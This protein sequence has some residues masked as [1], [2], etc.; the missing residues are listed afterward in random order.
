MTKRKYGVTSLVVFIALIVGAYIVVAAPDGDP[1]ALP[2]QTIDTTTIRWAWN[3]TSTDEDGF[4]VRDT[5]D[6]PIASVGAD[7]TTYDESSFSENTQHARRVVAY[8]ESA[9]SDQDAVNY[10][11]SFTGPNSTYTMGFEFTVNSDITV[12]SVRTYTNGQK[13]TIWDMSRNVLATVDPAV[14]DA[15]WPSYSL[16]SPLNLTAGQTYMIAVR[17]T[18]YYYCNMPSSTSD[19]TIERSWYDTADDFPDTNSTTVTMY[20]VVNF[21]YHTKTIDPSNPT[22]D[23]SKYTAVHDPTLSDFTLSDQG[24]AQVLIDV[25][26]PPNGTAGETGVFVQRILEGENWATDAVDV[27]AVYTQVYGVTDTVPA[28]GTYLYRIRFQNGDFVETAWSSDKKITIISYPPDKPLNFSGTLISPTSIEWGWTDDSDDEEGFVIQDT[29]DV[30]YVWANAGATTALETGLSENTE[31]TR[32]CRSFI[33]P[34]NAE[35][36]ACTYDGAYSSGTATNYRGI[37]F[38]PQADIEITRLSRYAGSVV[39]LHSDTGT[40]LEQHTFST[41]PDAEWVEEDL[42]TPW[43]LSAGVRYRLSTYDGGSSYT[44]YSD[45]LAS[46]TEVPAIDITHG[47]YGTTYPS[48]TSSATVYGLVNFR[49]RLIS[50]YAAGY[51]GGYSTSSTTYSRGFRFTPSAD[52]WVTKISRRA[53][54]KV[55]IHDDSGTLLFEHDFTLPPTGSWV[56]ASLT[57]FLKL[58]AGQTY[59]ISTWDNGSSYTYYYDAL[60]SVSSDSNITIVGGCNGNSTSG[61]WPINADPSYVRGV[62]NFAFKT[63]PN[64]SAASDTDTLYTPVHEPLDTDMQLTDAGSAEVVITITKP[65]NHDVVSTG[66]YIER[67]DDEFDWTSPTELASGWD[68]GPDGDG[69][70]YTRIDTVPS[71]G[72]WWYRMKFRNQVG[73]ETGWYK[74]S[75]FILSY[76]PA[77]PTGFQANSATITT[78]S[79]TWEWTDVATDE[80]GYEIR[81]GS[82]TWIADTAEDSSSFTE[83]GLSE[84]TPYTRKCLAYNLLVTGP[85]AKDQYQETIYSTVYQMYADYRY[86][87]TFTPGVSGE[88]TKVEF[89]GYGYD[90]ATYDVVVEI[91]PTSGG[92]PD[93]SSA[94]LAEVAL[95]N[96][97]T[98]AKWHT[99]TFASPPMLAAG[100][101]YA[102]VFRSDGTS[103]LSTYRNYIYYE[104][105]DAYAGGQYYFYNSATSTW[106]P[107]ATYDFMFRTHMIPMNRN[108]S[109]AS[110]D[111]PVYTLVHGPVAADLSLTD[112]HSNG[113]VEVVVTPPPNPTAG[114]TAVYIERDTDPGFSSPVEIGGGWTTTYT[115]TDTVPSNDLYYYRITFRNGDGT[116]TNSYVDSIDVIG[117]PPNEPLA[118]YGDTITASSITWNWTDDSSDETGFEVQDDT[119]ALVADVGADTSSVVESSLSENTAYT[120]HCRSYV[121]AGGTGVFPDI[122]PSAATP[123]SNPDVTFH[124]NGES[125]SNMQVVDDSLYWSCDR[126]NFPANDPQEIWAEFEF[127]ISSTGLSGSE[128]DSMTFTSKVYFTG[129]SGPPPLNDPMEIPYI[130]QAKVQ[131]YNVTSTTWETMGTDFFSVFRPTVWDTSAEAAIWDQTTDVNPENPIIR[132]K[133]S[134]W[135]EDYVSAS[136]IKI[137][138]YIQGGFNS[139]ADEAVWIFDHVK[140]DLT[141]AYTKLYSGPT[142][143]DTQYTLVH[144]PVD[145]DL[146]LTDLGS[147]Q[148]QI[149]VTEPLNSTLPQTGVYIE[150]DLEGDWSG[151]DYAVIDGDWTQTYTQTDTVPTNG[152]WKY[153]IKFRNQAGTETGWYQDSINIIHYPPA[154]PEDFL[155]DS[156]SVTA[157]SITWEW[158]DK[159]TDEAGFEIR[160]GSGGWLADAGEDA[161]SYTETGLEENTAYT[162]KCVAYNIPGGGSSFPDIYPSAVAPGGNPSAYAL[163]SNGEAISN[164]Q[165]ESDSLYWSCDYQNF[166]AVDP[167]ELWA[168]FS[169]DISSTGLSGSDIGTLTFTS[170]VYFTGN[171]GTVPITDPMEIQYIDEAKVQIYNFTSTTWETVGSDFLNDLGRGAVWRDAAES[172]LWDFITDVN[173]DNPVVR[174]KDSGW[175]TDYVSANTIKVRVY[176][177]GAF[178]SGNWDATWVFDHVKI[179]I[180]AE[181]RNYSTETSTDTIYTAVHDPTDADFTVTPGLWGKA[182][183][184]VM[185]PKNSTL[186]QTAVRIRRSLN[187]DMSGAVI[188]KDFGIEGYSFEDDVPSGEPWYY[189]I[190]FRN[191]QGLVTVESNSV[192][193]DIADPLSVPGSFSGQGIAV[194]TIEWTW[195][196]VTDADAYLF[197]DESGKTLQVITAPDTSC[198]D[199]V[200]GENT[201]STRQ[202]RS[203]VFS[204][205]QS[206]FEDTSGL[207]QTAV[208]W[209]SS[210]A[211]AQFLYTPGELSDEGT[212]KKIYWQRTDAGASFTYANVTVRLGHTTLTSLGTSFALNYTELDATVVRDP[213]AYVVPVT[214][215]PNE[216]LE[217]P[218]D[219][220]FYYNGVHN[221]IVDI[222]VESGDGD[223]GWSEVPVTDTCAISGGPSD[224]SASVTYQKKFLIRFDMD[225]PEY[226]SQTAGPVMAYSLVHDATTGDFTLNWPGGL[227]VDIVVTEPPNGTSGLTGVKIERATDQ[228]FATDV[229]LVQDFAAN[230][231]LTDT[232]PAADIYWYRITYCN[233]DGDA[234]GT[235]GVEYVVATGA[236]VAPTAGFVGMPTLGAAPLTVDFVDGSTGDT[237]G[238]SWDFEN[239]GTPD[240]T[241]QNPTHIYASAGVYTVSLTVTGPAG[242]DTE[243]KTDY[244][245]V[246][247]PPVAAFSASP[248]SGVVALTVDFTDESTGSITS[249][250]WDFDNDGTPDSALQH[251]SY[252][253][254][255]AG[256]YTVSLTV[257]GPGGSTTE[258]KI[259]HI[260]VWE[261]PGAAFSGTPTTGGVGL[262]VSFTDE[263][264]GDITSWS[265]D[266]DND[267][268]PDSTEQHPSYT[269]GAA[270]TYTVSLTVT[271]PGG[272]DTETKT[273][274]ITVYDAPLAAFSANPTSGLVA[275]SVDFTDESTG[276]ITSWSWDFD[277]DGTPDSILQHPSHIYNTAGTYTVSLTVTGPGGSDTETR[278]DYISVWEPPAAEFS[279][280]P[281][282]G[283]APLTVDFL[284]ES[285]GDITSWSWDFDND[286]TPDSMEQHPS[287]IYTVVGTYTVSL[288]VSGPGGSSTETKVDYITVTGAPLAAFSAN[289]TSGLVALAVDFTD[290]STGSITSWSWDFDDDGTPDSIQQHPSYTYTM[291]GTYTVSLTV[292]G[293]GG[294][295]TETK[296]DYI[297]VW[298]P[299]VAEFSASPTSGTSPLVVDFTDEST[300]EVTSWEWDFENDGTP[301]STEQHPSHTYTMP[302]LYTVSLTVSGPG[303]SDTVTKIDYIEVTDPS[304][305]AADFSASP[306]SGPAPLAVAFT[307]LSTGTYTSVAWDFDGDGTID[308]TSANPTHTYNLVGTYTV[309]LTIDGPD[310]D[311]TET[312]VDYI[313]VTDPG[314]IS[315]E[316]TAAPTSGGPPL[317]VQFTDLSVGDIASWSWDFGNGG[318]SS[319]RSPSYQYTVAGV[320]TVTLTVTGPAGS[321]SEIKT[322]YITVGSAP[323]PPASDKKKGGCSCA[324]DD[325]PTPLDHLIGYFAPLF[326]IA[327]AWLAFRRRGARA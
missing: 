56:E 277:N 302:G 270:G 293:P 324:V 122:Y 216:W 215:S 211:R 110:T 189:A 176:M 198:Q 55:S 80:A 192:L 109:N 161:T 222:I 51:D 104:N 97:G 83:S 1:T 38:T 134:G 259:D 105:S 326:L 153:R 63:V 138:V 208:P 180:M 19:I 68:D 261:P 285:T 256:T 288:T 273:D 43:Q 327:C 86:A 34:Y 239:D 91:Y 121:T 244:I 195:D 258:T 186:L 126:Q 266:F 41:S 319:D 289:P 178:D 159:S 254:N 115:H 157:T 76:P 137:R 111:G 120:R 243:T 265:W 202:L 158:T 148:V 224:G 124:S 96:I 298:E 42:A 247:E 257:T 112:L 206:G 317:D 185:P 263:S 168:E 141:E 107:T 45:P 136:I 143:D 295:D 231:S 54:S 44:Y 155:A 264:T 35:A 20:G 269:Y 214:G 267:G 172:L 32:Q 287:Y 260:T 30:N 53:G 292:T 150:R 10:P 113:Q 103:S 26:A 200:S 276:A 278:I 191:A 274:Y 318:T 234:S 66:V 228:A 22:A 251:P 217:I 129:S 133:D 17:T 225:V 108:Y 72:T 240:S 296:T 64:Y 156:A 212:I 167:Q 179:D 221:L 201:P 294:S 242:S 140:I 135:S 299:P 190:T 307:D 37:R 25:T 162:R 320:Y 15:T 313:T 197:K 48:S 238:W 81:D 151:P 123:G 62:P 171:T 40:L 291:A 218:L 241:E 99:A 90:A 101:L 220:T 325:S 52:I 184:D 57:Q 213:A 73:V 248:T 117:Y 304:V 322:D 152:D 279:G 312:K 61:Q 187:S 132:T 60:G 130:D 210:G 305:P 249:W 166:P 75:I 230:Y 175:S 207:G 290:E 84:N 272:S 237:T 95:P 227:S 182:T 5:S 205:I 233:G 118:F 7:V 199:I 262:I 310:G 223:A 128:I 163:V 89:Y 314:S 188:V 85:E 23:M 14:G 102:M 144:E 226:Q 323:P 58:S 33:W 252:I 297:T 147:A 18:G 142:A 92:E 281:T 209:A 93:R 100:T 246:T 164:M 219:R 194:D 282:T 59:R 39:S 67:S 204:S 203:C 146:V 21:I 87:Q 309:T 275:L 139:T 165:A 232:I 268:T 77:D 71:N 286:G 79:I 8:T 169:F 27:T 177:N 255:T 193:A 78:T 183:I 69:D 181:N 311:D 245:T 280:D 235:S 11:G 173:P 36:D 300:G 170:K 116:P 149:T 114:S 250:S 316:F 65:V 16:S 315:A 229:T 46:V 70:P 47:C 31:Y 127:D 29:S 303:G 301:D 308:S 12:T 28:N 13:V 94:P 74:D 106:T 253:Y 284:D 174:T 24:S 306:T 2:A 236:P 283:A 9:G 6:N 160:D 49:Y 154:D 82:D 321:D 98:G 3:D 271:G 88:L 131:I 50:H 125:I 119:D 196:E 4:Q 145:T